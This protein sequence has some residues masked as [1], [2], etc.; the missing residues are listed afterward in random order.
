MANLVAYGSLINRTELGN[1][2]AF[3][4]RSF[5]PIKVAGFKRI[6]N[7]EPTWRK[8][9]GL[10]R[11]VLNVVE[12]P[13]DWHNAIL[14]RDVPAAYFERLDH[15]ERGYIR[16][17]V[18]SSLI[19]AYDSVAEIPT[20]PAYIYLGRP[21]KSHD[22]LLPNEKYMGTCLAG[23]RRWGNVFLEDFLKTTFVRGNI[24]LKEY[25]LA[26]STAADS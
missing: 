17:E 20:T 18:D 23:A 12:S 7:R 15:R 13:S 24:P 9:R 14:I 21:E 25:L 5:T 26:N 4:T 19:R 1:R 6:F 2:T 22:A 11:S 10:R 16:T 3:Q 8:G